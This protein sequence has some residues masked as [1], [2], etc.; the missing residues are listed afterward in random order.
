V[1]L[2]NLFGLVDLGIVTVQGLRFDF[3]EHVGAM[4]Y[5]VASFLP[6]LL[7]SHVLIFKQLGRPWQGRGSRN[8]VVAA[9][10]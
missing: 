1:W 5:V 2:T 7:L 8:G 3:A 10:S 6:W 9:G 4:F